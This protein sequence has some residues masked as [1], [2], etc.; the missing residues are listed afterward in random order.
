LLRLCPDEAPSASTTGLEF[1][2]EHELRTDLR[3]DLGVVDRALSDGEWKAA[4]VLAG[5]V[6]EALLLWKLAQFVETEIARIRP[7]ARDLP[8]KPLDKWDLADYIE[9]ASRLKVIDKDVTAQTATRAK[10]PQPHPPG[11]RSTAGAK[12]HQGYNAFCDCRDVSHD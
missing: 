11:S 6:I 3:T 7:G 8:T 2:T 10:L 4:T 5:S 9:A 1:I 12:M